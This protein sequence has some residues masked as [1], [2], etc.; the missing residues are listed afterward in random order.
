MVTKI[1]DSKI[2]DGS[3]LL[4]D[5]EVQRADAQAQAASREVSRQHGERVKS[6]QRTQAIDTHMD[7]QRR[8]QAQAVTAPP[9]AA[10]SDD[11]KVEAPSRA[12][13]SSERSKGFA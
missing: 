2:L 13:A 5:P 7:E 1:S 12:I 4:E 9:P 3:N 8:V 6:I 11:P 10:R